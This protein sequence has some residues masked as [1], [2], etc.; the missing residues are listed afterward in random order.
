MRRKVRWGFDA[1][2]P[3]QHLRYI[4]GRC[5]GFGLVAVR[6]AFLVCGLQAFEQ[7]L[8]LLHVPLNHAPV[9]NAQEVSA[10]RK[11]PSEGFRRRDAELVQLGV[12][13]A[14]GGGVRARVR[15]V[16]GR[17]PHPGGTGLGRR[18]GAGD[19]P[20][21]GDPGGAQRRCARHEAQ[22][23]GEDAAARPGRWIRA[24]PVREPL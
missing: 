10:A 16:R 7:A 5:V 9:Q 19:R 11:P 15:G 3:P 1:V 17:R 6:R 23:G 2:N 8:R 21:R 22:R 24:T 18:S 20:L 12:G 13:S 4:S 14:A